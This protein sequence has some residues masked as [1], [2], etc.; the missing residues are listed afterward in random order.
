MQALEIPVVVAINKT[1]LVKADLPW[2][3]ENTQQLLGTRPVPIAAR[4]GD[5]IVDKLLP[6][7]LD[8]QPTIAVAIARALPGV[9]QH[10]V[11]R[12]IRRTAWTNA[13]IALEPFPG[14][15]IPLLLTAQTRM[16]L[17]IA[18]AHGVSMRV[19]HARELLTT[20]AGSLLSRYLSGQLV[21]LIPG[22]GWILSGI[23]A[24]MSTWAIGHAAQ[25]YFQ[26]D[27]N[28]KPPDLQAFYQRLRQLAPRQWWTHLRQ[29]RGM[30]VS[31][32]ESQGQLE[33]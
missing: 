5:G 3:L 30:E 32:L 27:G 12:I 6:A 28:I 22:P 29:R 1:D 19:S 2:I 7:I 18:A 26:T 4:S 21:K 14:L 8:A 15:D 13:I 25:R 23:M 31:E 20:M 24:A 11:Q 16:V 10:L 33:V 9:R 17:R